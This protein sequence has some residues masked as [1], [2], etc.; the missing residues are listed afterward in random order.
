MIFCLIE[1][2]LGLWDDDID[3]ECLVGKVNVRCKNW[4][5]RNEWLLVQKEGKLLG[6]AKA[7]EKKKRKKRELEGD[8]AGVLGYLCSL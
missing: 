3:K 5:A 2:R 6:E 4:L 8:G 1:N 7:E